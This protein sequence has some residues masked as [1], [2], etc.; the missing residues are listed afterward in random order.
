MRRKKIGL[1]CNKDRV[2]RRQLSRK[3]LGCPCQSNEANTQVEIIPREMHA[4][5]QGKIY[6]PGPCLA[7]T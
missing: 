4:K 5:T 7:L 1:Q 6:G 2:S 3:L